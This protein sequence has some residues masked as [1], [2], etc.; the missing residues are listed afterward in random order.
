MAI[1][2]RKVVLSLGQAG[3]AGLALADLRVGFSVKMNKGPN[4]HTAT[5]QVYNAN[6]LTLATLEAGPLPT[7][8]LKVGY[9]DPLIPGG[10]ITIPRS[11]FLGEVVK[12]GLTITREGPDRIATI[13]AQ[14]TPG[15]YQL[16]RVALT[17][18]T[19]VS[20]SAVV[21]AVAAQL[22]LPIGSIVVAPDVVLSQGGNFVGDARRILDRIAASVGGRWWISDGVF[23]F[24][25][26]GVPVPGVAPLFSSV[27]GNLI[28]IPAKKDRG[29][30]QVTGLLDA[31]VRPG[32]AFAVQSNSVNGT[33]IATDVEFLGDSGFDQAFYVRVVGELPG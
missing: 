7:V 11:I 28:G 19:A 24:A 21:A 2:G 6:P 31:S 25:P 14:D 26:A 3:V 8:Q 20:M 17:Y 13:E 10:G 33:Y 1:F 27:T 29:K 5:I 22:A 12:G 9:A 15:A 23:F 32:V 30:I 4:P 18:P 16:G